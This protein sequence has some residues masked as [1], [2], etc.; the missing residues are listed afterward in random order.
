MLAATVMI[1]LIAI[2]FFF[3]WLIAGWTGALLLGLWVMAT[4]VI[5]QVWEKQ[6]LAKNKV[7]LAGMARELRRL[8]QGF[9]PIDDSFLSRRADEYVFYVRDGLQL[10]EF[11]SSGRTTSGGYGGASFRLSKN[12]SISA[13]G[14]KATSQSLPE[15][16][17]TID[18]GEVVFTNQR[19][20][21][22]GPNHTREWD[23]SKLLGM[24]ISDNGFEVSAAVSGRQKTSALAG[25]CGGMLTPGFAFALAAEIFQFGEERAQKLATEI[26]QDIEAHVRHEP[27]QSQ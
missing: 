7:A 3:V 1:A 15:E 16:S 20:V 22:S 17:K 12:L 6:K 19:V 23:L 4:L 10:R 21:F 26:A 13:G 8:A 5:Y 9:E 18:T 14:I 27:G 25:N 24:Q 2:M 11:K